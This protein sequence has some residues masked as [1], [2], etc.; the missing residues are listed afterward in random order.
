MTTLTLEEVKVERHGYKIEDC[1]IYDD[2]PNDTSP[3]WFTDD[4]SN[5][6]QLCDG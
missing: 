1:W 6:D 5:D 4:N 3:R 2:D